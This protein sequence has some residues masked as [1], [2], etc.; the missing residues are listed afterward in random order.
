LITITFYTNYLTVTFRSSRSFQDLTKVRV[1]EGVAG[2]ATIPLFYYFGYSGMLIRVV[3]VA[4]LIAL[5]MHSLRPIHVRPHWSLSSFL[6]LLRTG[7]PIFALDYLSSIAA[8]CDRLILLRLGGTKAVGIYAMALLAREAIDVVPRAVGEY[9]YPRM[10][11]AYGQHHNSGRLWGAA[12]KSSLLVV[13]MMVPVA[14]IGWL[15]MPPVVM[16]LFPKY[17]DGITAARLLLLAAIFSGATL[18]R[19]AIWSLKAWKLM[20]CYQAIGAGF[21]VAGALLGVTF[22]RE[23]LVGVSAGLLTAQVVWCPVAWTL[24]YAATHPATETALSEAK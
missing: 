13:A 16:R 17:A 3:G 1:V 12:V 22:C 21:T 10:S 5:A 19:T 15:L 4:A 8:T 2:L 9:V 7:A 14:I 20:V 24:I 6:L 23:P 18:G 11:Y